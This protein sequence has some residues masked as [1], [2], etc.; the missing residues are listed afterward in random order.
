MTGF[1]SLFPDPAYGLLVQKSMRAGAS[2]NYVIEP[3]PDN[4]AQDYSY[5][6]AVWSPGQHAVPGA[7]M[8]LGL[9]LGGALRAVNILAAVLA[10]AGWFTLFRALAF[11]PVVALGACL[12]IAASRTFGLSFLAYVGSDQLAF[13]AFPF[14]AW[15]VFRARASWALTLIAPAAVLAGFFLKN[16]MAIYVTAWIAGTLGATVLLRCRRSARA[17]SLVAAVVMAVGGALFLIDW[18]YVSRGWTPMTY[19]PAWSTNPG[20]YLLPAAMPLLAG[21]GL[22]D[23]LSRVFDHPALPKVDYKGSLVLLVP[24]VAGMIAWAVSECRQ[25]VRRDVRL[26]ILAFVAGVAAV[27]TVFLATGS[28]ASVDLSRHYMI[29]GAMLLPL[30]VERLR[31]CQSRALRTILVLVIALPALYGVSSFGANWRRHY[32]HRAA[33]SGEV[34]VAHLSLTPRLVQYLRMLDRDLPGEGSLVVLPIPSLAFEFSRTRVLATSAT[35]D[36]IPEFSKT[37][38]GGRVANLVVIAEQAGQTPDEIRAWLRTFAAYD[39][40][41]WEHVSVDGFAFHFPRGQRVDAQWLQA[42]FGGE[43]TSCVTPIGGCS[44]SSPSCA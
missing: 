39:P 9:T 3:R 14:L 19:R 1:P 31:A 42:V 8:S 43:R 24:I 12:V 10:I 30:Y 6:Y 44:R 27:F 25:A 26:A 20:R 22:D 11:E 13:A 15:A 2:W 18:A 23:L 41:A 32:E 4:I 17:W 35:S 29:P 33:H 37:T 36:G 16:S 5:F 7:L 40:E 21:T 38:W 28:G 34:G